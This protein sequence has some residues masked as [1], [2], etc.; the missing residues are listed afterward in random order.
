M[1][2]AENLSVPSPVDR[3]EAFPN[4]WRLLLSSKTFLAGLAVI[5]VWTA[6]A[7][8]GG[9]IAP[10]DPFATAVLQ[11]NQA[12]SWNHWFGTD[13]LGRDVFA[14]V[15]V[16]AQD[17][18]TVAPLATLGATALGTVLGL[19]TGYFRGRVDALVMQVVDAFLAIPLVILGL[20]TL[21]ALGP[22]KWAVVVVIAIVFTPM[23]TRTVRAAVFAERELEY[24]EAAQ[25]R[26]ENAAYMMFVEILPN[27]A[28]PILVEAT[29]RLGYAIFAIATLSFL[30][31]GI[32][33]PSPDWGLQ[34]SSN[35]ALID[36][37]IWWSTL[38]PAL[39]IASLVI[40]VSLMSDGLTQVLE[41]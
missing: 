14:R 18:L 41:Q 31:F 7:I 26:R 20:L 32:Q 28:A 11:G 2:V 9:A 3:A 23:I 29:V 16:G 10:Q 22:S 13:T 40:G 27:V 17:I 38:F 12:P 34:I 5:V 30:G 24:V 21:T 25:L 35:Y 1:V 37:G 6:C 15:I 8:L 36:G 39:A 19:T 4:R 33:P